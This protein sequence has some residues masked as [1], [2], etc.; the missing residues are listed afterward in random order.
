MKIYSSKKVVAGSMLSINDIDPTMIEYAV[1]KY[2]GKP[3]SEVKQ[4]LKDIG[5]ECT[6][7]AGPSTKGAE[8]WEEWTS[9]GDNPGSTMVK[10]YFTLIKSGNRY[11]DGDLTDVYVDT[12]VSASTN[13]HKKK[14]V[15]A[16]PGAGYTIDWIID[17]YDTVN[18]FTVDSIEADNYGTFNVTVSCDIAATGTITGAHSYGYGFTEDINDVKINIT[19]LYL[20]GVESPIDDGRNDYDAAEL[21]DAIRTMSS[22][23]LIEMVE[24]CDNPD[25]RENSYSYG[26]GY[27]HSTYD[28]TIA[29]IDEDYSQ[30][31]AYIEDKSVIEYIDRCVSG[32]CEIHTYGLFDYDGDFIESYDDV[33][34]AKEAAQQLIDSGEYDFIECLCQIEFERYNGDIDYVDSVTEFTLEA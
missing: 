8:T 26:G 22:Q 25:L 11:A 6:L 9:D 19:Q 14:P 34:D 3:V 30:M 24:S 16:G 28:G 10:I 27:I 1:E 18:S 7:I 32:D 21:E 23:D 31:T 5:F 29:V 12:F 4:Y 15:M 13:T 2:I 33:E 20:E 17:S